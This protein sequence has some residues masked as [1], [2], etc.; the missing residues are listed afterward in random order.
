MKISV[1]VININNLDYTKN[2]VKDL[3]RQTYPFELTVVDQGSTELGTSEFLYSLEWMPHTKVIRNT[4]NEDV[5]QLW[6][7][8]YM[9]SQSSYLCF[10]NN[11]MRI[12]SKFIE[13]TVK[14]FD[15]EDKVGCVLHTTNYNSYRETQVSLDYQIVP[16]RLHQG[17]CCSFRR[18][19]YSIIP[20]EIRFFGGDDHVFTQMY[21]KGWQTAMVT[22]SPVIH[23]CS[24]SRQ[25]YIED[26]QENWNKF[27]KY[28]ISQKSQRRHEFTRTKPQFRRILEIE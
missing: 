23:Y 11:D 13:D 12:S 3:E 21:N 18:E 15:I 16:Y 1:L 28:G 9:Q 7:N 26:R 8:H 22:S 10:L 2:L 14:V 20:E 17:W 24:K 19:V 5:N 4:C 25:Y 27:S 6:N